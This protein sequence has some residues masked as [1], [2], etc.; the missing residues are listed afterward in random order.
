MLNATIK[1]P[2]VGFCS[3]NVTIDH[4]LV[5]TSGKGCSN[6]AGLGQGLLSQDCLPSGASHGG[7][8]G[9][10]ASLNVNATCLSPTAYWKEDV[11]FY[12]GSSGAYGVS[13]TS[14]NGGGVIWV[15]V[16]NTVLL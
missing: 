3:P 8:G 16:S 2:K 15:T 5:D 1:G 10:G 6:G 13:G 9:K 14:G 7:R 12:E 4:S 11:A